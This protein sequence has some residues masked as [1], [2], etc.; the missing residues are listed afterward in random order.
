MP[1][2]SAQNLARGMFLE[3]RQVLQRYDLPPGQWPVAV[4]LSI[5]EIMEM[6]KDQLAPTLMAQI[7]MEMAVPA[8]KL[9]PEALLK[10]AAPA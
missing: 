6:A 2:D 3:V 9:D 1:A 7:V 5:Q 8:S 10:G 4:A